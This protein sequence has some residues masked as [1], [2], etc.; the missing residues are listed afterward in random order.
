M[1]QIANVQQSGAP[2]LRQTLGVAQQM[3]GG[4][5]FAMIFQQLLSGTENGFSLFGALE[6]GA[7]LSGKDAEQ[8]KLSELGGQMMAEMLAMMPAF[9]TQEIGAQ[10]EA[11]AATG[12][13]PV[14][15]EVAYRSLE[16]LQ[17]LQV[18]N[19]VPA[20]AEEAELPLD[21]DFYSVL[22]SSW[23]EPEAPAVMGGM[24]FSSDALRTARQLLADK[25]KEQ[26]ETLDLESLQA[27]VTAKRFLPEEMAAQ[28][29]QTTALPDTEEIASQI[30]TGVLKNV[31]KGK[32]EF[33]IR[34]KPEGIGEVTVKISEDKSTISLQ[35]FTTS[36]QTAKMITDEVASLQNALRPLHAEVQ[37]VT[38][39]PEGYAS[40]AAMDG[41]AGQFTG[42]QFGWQQGRQQSQHFRFSD[43][44]FEESVRQVLEDDG[45]DAYI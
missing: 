39:V 12:V 21:S 9:Q 31:A 23:K 8:K 41:G 10:L 36:Q 3:Q 24:T 32:N 20:E 6:E 35:I 43:G 7:F 26:P 25:Q 18:Q 30:K 34:L 13:L 33:V 15:D 2:S 38:V 42:Q 5:A 28:P 11:F 45:L 16:G 37:Q 14:G 40:Q 19:A 4:D 17:G 1:N 29:V 22:S 27:D 44:E